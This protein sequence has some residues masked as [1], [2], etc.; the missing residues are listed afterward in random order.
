MSVR[1]T[2]AGDSPGLAGA[3]TALR[4]PRRTLNWCATCRVPISQTASA[5][6]P[7]CGGL[8][9]HLANDVRPVFSRERRILQFYGHGPLIDV[10]VWK[11]SKAKTYYV[12]GHKVS[13][14]TAD[15][16]Q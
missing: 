13:L 5:P 2:V 3:S 11:A 10:P 16:L 1:A 4:M 7:G 14:P 8:T 6:C 9:R 12:D 15:E